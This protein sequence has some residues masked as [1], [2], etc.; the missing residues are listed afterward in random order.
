M[1]NSKIYKR[2]GG[3]DP[4]WEQGALKWQKLEEGRKKDEKGAGRMIKN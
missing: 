3:F 1:K 2:A 4:I